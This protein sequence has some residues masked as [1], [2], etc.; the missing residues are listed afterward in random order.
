VGR[1]PDREA[2]VSCDPDEFRHGLLLAY[3][4]LETAIEAI[5]ADY[6]FLNEG[7]S[8]EDAV[9][10]LLRVPDAAKSIRAA[11]DDFNQKVVALQRRSFRV[12]H[13]G[14]Q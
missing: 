11:C 10:A 5:E 2:A 12:L 4:E 1:G 7:C 8:S 6:A 9:D 3:L 13:G 14:R